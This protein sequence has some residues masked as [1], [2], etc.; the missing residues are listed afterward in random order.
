MGAVALVVGL[1]ALVMQPAGSTNLTGTTTTTTTSLVSTAI[2]FPMGVAD[3]TE[4]SGEAPM[5]ANALAGYTQTYV[6]DFNGTSLPPGWDVF[7][8]TASGD[9]GSQFGPAHVTVSNGLLSLNTW[10]DP[11][12]GNEWVTGGLCQC[13]GSP[14][15][16]GAF[17]VRSR[18]TGPGPTLVELLW[19]TT[20]W[21][22]EVDFT[23]TDGSTQGNAAT[24]IWAQ[25]GE[26][27]QIHLDVDMTQW[28][29]W[30]VVW[31]PTTL[32]YTIDGKVWGQFGDAAD[33]P[34]QPMALHIQQQTWC[35]FNF[36]CP[37]LPQSAQIDWIAEYS[38]VANYTTTLGPFAPDNSALN[39]PLKTQI[40]AL[41]AS[42]DTQGAE[43]VALTGYSDSKTKAR[44]ARAIGERRA[45][46]VMSYLLSALSGLNDNGVT[47][48]TSAG[49]E[50]NPTTFTTTS[51]GRARNARVVVQ[52]LQKPST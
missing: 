13:N 27:N 16:Y 45:S 7:A 25:N 37:T 24:D 6:N 10:L 36:A 22:P 40:L 50:T 8:G 4:P 44:N 52:F 48:T 3:P 42:I 20:S 41:A 21:P 1:F 31:T 11:S 33:I 2:Q 26:K 5:P 34:H 43:S 30:G 49:N 19:P 18:V 14:L 17:F 47:V 38:P 46:T 15:T 28:H 32:F 35:A 12:Y 9:T 51:S 29:T 23:E 39:G